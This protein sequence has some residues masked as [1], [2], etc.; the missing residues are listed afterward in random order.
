MSLSRIYFISS[1]VAVRLVAGVHLAIAVPR[2]TLVVVGI[3]VIRITIVAPGANT[4][5]GRQR[6]APSSAP[7]R[8]GL[9]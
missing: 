3:A 9:V 7:T 6:P 8:F 2:Q 1:V 5:A 4:D